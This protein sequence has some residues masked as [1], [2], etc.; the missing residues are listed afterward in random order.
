MEKGSSREDCGRVG[1]RADELAAV[2]DS[3]AFPSKAAVTPIKTPSRRN[4][5]W[6]AAVQRSG[7]GEDRTVSLTPL[8]EQLI[9]VRRGLGL[10]MA[11]RGWKDS[12]L[13]RVVVPNA[14]RVLSLNCPQ[15]YVS[16]QND[17]SSS[18]QALQPLLRP[19]WLDVPA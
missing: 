8:E 2:K 7:T 3:T 11:T 19:G 14:G 17:K 5:F 16:R 6:E 12:V 4:V 18:D 15:P 9:P 1:D 10:P 13:L